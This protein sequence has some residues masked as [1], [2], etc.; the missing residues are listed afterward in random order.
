M[1]KDFFFCKN[2]EDLDKKTLI[3][4][5]LLMVLLVSI[6]SSIYC[7][8]IINKFDELTDNNFNIIFKNIQFEYG[9]LIHN[10]YYNFDYSFIDDDGII[11]Y[12]K[13]LPLH[14][15]LL[16]SIAKISKNIFFIFIFKNIILFSLLFIS[17]MRTILY[18]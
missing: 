3:Y 8:L 6:L 7:Y 4:I 10:I 17:V 11:Y 9:K 15:L 16:V 5:Y 2:I 13:R 1:L 14:P 12:L 18:F